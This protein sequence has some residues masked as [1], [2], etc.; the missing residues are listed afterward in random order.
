[1]AIFKCFRLWGLLAASIVLS[2]CVGGQ[3]DRARYSGKV[4]FEDSQKPAAGAFVLATWYGTHGPWWV[5]H[6]S[7]TCYHIEA[8]KTDAEG[9][10]QLT[11]NAKLPSW[12]SHSRL[13]LIAY[14]P[15]F[16]SSHTFDRPL[17]GLKATDSNKQWEHINWLTNQTLCAGLPTSEHRMAI[18]IDPLLNELESL[19]STPQQRREVEFKRESLRRFR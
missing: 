14:M 12:W 13:S 19:A 2:S 3:A 1:M 18:I 15:G 16:A 8:M 7:T 9:R 6:S 5:G 17:I 10:Y 4:A 11:G